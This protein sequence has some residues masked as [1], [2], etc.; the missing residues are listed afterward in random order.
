[1]KDHVKAEPV[2]GALEFLRGGGEMGG[3]IRAFDWS[4]TPIGS[5]A[6]WSPALRMLLRM[7]LANRF[8]HILWWG[9][10]YIQFYNDPYIPIPGA[11]HPDRSLGQPARQCWSEIWHV[12]G[13]LIDRPFCGGAATWDDDIYLEINRNG[14]VEE[15]HFTIAYSPIPDE[16]APGGIGGVLATVHEITAKVVG[17]RRGVTLRELAARLSKAQTVEHVFNL[18]AET[19]ARHNKDVP[20]AAVYYKGD[21]VASTG[22]CPAEDW[23]L[24]EEMSLVGGAVVMPVAKDVHVVAGISPLLRFDEFYRDFFALVRTQIATAITNVRAYEEERRR[25]EA[26]AELDRL[27]TAFF[28]NISHEFRTPLTLM[29]GPLQEALHED[30]RNERL[31]LAHRNSL[32]LLKLVNS[33]LDFSRIEAGR[34]DA[35][36]EP[37]DLGTY[38]AE[39][40]SAFRSAIEKAGI[41]FSVDCPPLPDAVYV[42]REMWEKIV[43][44]LLSNAFKFTFEGEIQVALRWREERVEL[45]VRDTGV[46]I[47]EADLPKVFQRF[48]RV[49]GAQS[50]THEG[51]GIGLA[52]V[53]ELARL[54]GGDIDVQSREGEGSTF[55]VTI[56]TGTAHLPSHKVVGGRSP[57]SPAVGASPYVEEALRWFPEKALED[58]QNEL[59]Q[60]ELLAVPCPPSEAEGQRDRPRIL[61]A[62]DNA[63]M[64]QYVAR[65]LAERYQVETVTDGRAALDAAWARRP[66]LILSDIMMPKLDGVGLLRA[67]REHPATKAI[68]IILLSARAGEE[69]RVE[70][71]ERGADDYLIKPFSARELLARVA[72]HLDM[73]RVRRE[74]GERTA[75]ELRAM[76]RLHEVGT[77]CVRAGNDFAQCLDGILDAAIE[78]TGACKGNIQLI[79]PASGALKIAAQRGFGARFLNFFASVASDACAGGAAMRST[80]R[81]VVEDV[82]QSQLFEGQPSLGVLLDAGVRAVQSTPLISSAGNILGMVSTH[83]DKPARPDE[84][85]LR[86]MDLLA[87]QAADYLE[88]RQADKTLRESE[89]RFRALVEQSPFG[90]YVVNSH[91]RIVHM[92]EAGQRGAFRNVKPLIGRDFAEAMGV[93]WPEPVAAE[94]IRIFRHTLDTGESYS[95]HDFINSRADV[96]QTEAYE[97]ELHRL[98]L[99]DGQYGVICYYFDSTKLRE[100]ETAL[101]TAQGRLE[102]WNREL[103]Q[104]VTVKT[105]QL[106]QSQQQL[107][108]FASELNFAEQRERKRLATEM[109]DHLQQLLVLGKMQVGQ[110]K[111]YAVGVP[112]CEGIMRKIDNTLSEA[113]AYTR[114]LVSE[115][116]PPVLRDH[117]IAAGLKWLGESMR[118]KHDFAVTVTV[119]DNPGFLLPDDHSVL[120]FQSVRELLI[121]AWKHAGT[122]EAAVS[123]EYGDGSLRIMVADKGAGFDL[124]AAAAVGP[125]D[126]PSEG[127]SSKFGLFSIRERMRALDGSFDIQSVPGQGTTATLTLPLQGNGHQRYKDAHLPK[128]ASSSVSPNPSLIPRTSLPSRIRLLL[129]DDHTMV[130]KGLRSVLD[131]YADLEVVGEAANGE[132]SMDQVVKHEPAVVLMDISMPKING[133]EATARIKER[134]PHIH[135]IGLSV[136][137]DEENQSAMLKAGAATLLTKEAAVE[138][139]Y[140]TIQQVMRH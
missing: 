12:I 38:T 66:D 125:A 23:T 118:A 62:D 51:T 8:P 16:T 139:L 91:F 13:P 68:P 121:N 134:H 36:Y 130:R 63:D 107:R 119:P 41:R 49:R 72:A 64:R 22:E 92:N 56:Q 90:I 83:F 27:K 101:R 28:S 77:R 99:Q 97:W 110:G 94:I 18:A 95:S 138:E 103:E 1:M 88:R 76:T 106:C 55:T 47:P 34:I 85:Q 31:A 123:L 53:Q 54:H 61:L 114:T 67:L 112:D 69:S 132:E 42:D 78:L 57:V 60:R 4:T 75:A 133:I 37:T 100:T 7:M 21:L 89:S 39:L 30:P 122:G 3:R 124:A 65:L 33:L 20:F 59:L 126:T 93:L 45:S 131:G 79:D 15:T 104:A 80:E 5:P 116:S 19:F 82:T 29:L 87:R 117:G 26:L 109:H 17:E 137:A 140:K 113:L 48:H 11:K 129:V 84:R 135:V 70:G 52:L 58:V 115:L 24:S 98:M 73:A 96:E 127:L 136:N 6:A 35:S 108:A 128:R 46:G 10:D 105:A 40:A 50:R 9:P 32:R 71:L 120:L 102:Q 44:N 74:S 14:F 81:V 86:L 2:E 111:R 25:A 43:L